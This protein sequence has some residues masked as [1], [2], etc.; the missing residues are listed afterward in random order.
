MPY[1]NIQ[2]TREGVTREQKAELIAGATD[3]VVRV[4]NKDPAA[5]FVVIDE[6]DTDNWG[7]AGESMT[8]V[9]ARQKAAAR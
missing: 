3:L 6:V 8:V 9:R 5:T 4:L 1:I 2:V 7:F